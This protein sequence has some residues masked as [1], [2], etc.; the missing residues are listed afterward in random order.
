MGKTVNLSDLSLGGDATILEEAR[1]KDEAT[2][3]KSPEKRLTRQ[4]K[5]N[6]TSTEK[7]RIEQKADDLGISESA[8]VRMALKAGTQLL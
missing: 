6:L 1:I 5:L 2:G 8:V 4:I 7:K 3:Y